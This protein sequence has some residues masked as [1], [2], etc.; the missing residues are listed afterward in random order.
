MRYY[1][2]L[3]DHDTAVE[4]VLLSPQLR[5]ARLASPIGPRYL[6]VTVTDV[7]VQMG[8]QTTTT[9]RP[10]PASRTWSGPRSP[11]T[12]PTTTRSVDPV[13]LADPQHG[14]G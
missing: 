14:R 10:I 11:T 4:L 12:G 8:F 9:T 1:R 2:A 7:V 6:L 3:G 13:R 5:T